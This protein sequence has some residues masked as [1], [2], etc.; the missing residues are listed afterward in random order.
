M[1]RLSKRWRDEAEEGLNVLGIKNGQAVIRDCRESGKI[2][3]VE[4][5][6]DLNF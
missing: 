5:F 1:E 3:G 2:V 6:V 4:F